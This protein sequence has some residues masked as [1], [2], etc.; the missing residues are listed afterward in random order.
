MAQS[1]LNIEGI[2]LHFNNYKTFAFTAEF[3]GT[4]RGKF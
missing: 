3:L 4:G 2:N 1:T